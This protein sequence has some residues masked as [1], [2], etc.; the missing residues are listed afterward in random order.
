MSALYIMKSFVIWQESFLLNMTH[1]NKNFAHGAMNFFMMQYNFF[2]ILYDNKHATNHDCE[3]QKKGKNMEKKLTSALIICTRN[4]CTDVVNALASVT[5]QTRMPEEIIIVDSSDHKLSE[6]PLFKDFFV[7]EKFPGARLLYYH[8]NPGLPYQRNVGVTLATTKLVHFIDDDVLLESEYLAQMCAPFE[9]DHTY[10]GGMGTVINLPKKKL[11]IFRFIR[12][13]FFLQ[14][15]Y[16]PGNFTLSGMPTHAY[17]TSE[18]KAVQ[19]LGG[20]CMSYR[21]I[22]FLKHRFDE[23]LGRYAWMEDCDFS[24]RVSR[25]GALFFNPAARLQHLNSPVS[26]DSQMAI[27]K[28]FMKNYSYLFF[29]NFYPRNRLRIFAYWWTIVGLFLEALVIRDRHHVRGYVQG[30]WQY[31]RGA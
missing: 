16:A 28:L 12:R 2:H 8:T 13:L 9:A 23:T 18:F 24:W 4:R 14:R 27:S 21:K 5:Q 15:N 1:Y 7:S 31:R 22:I 17:G 20:C 10:L 11:E 3:K 30:L 6:Q 29:K 26:R 25:D 19:A